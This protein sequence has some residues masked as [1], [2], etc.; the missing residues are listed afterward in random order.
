MVTCFLEMSTLTAKMLSGVAVIPLLLRWK[1][2]DHSLDKCFAAKIQM[3]L[4]S[5]DHHHPGANCV[6][7][8]PMLCSTE[9][10]SFQIE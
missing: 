3:L 10:A 1:Y 7:L 2:S 8:S 9:L 6:P 5:A 4:P